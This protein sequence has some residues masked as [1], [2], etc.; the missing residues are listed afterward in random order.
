MW[1]NYCHVFSMI[2]S[3]VVSA[4]F[5]SYLVSY[6]VTRFSDKRYAK[7]NEKKSTNCIVQLSNPKQNYQQQ[8]EQL[9]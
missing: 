3:C 5:V 9:E 1:V 6:F 7:C 4:I 2:H 8:N